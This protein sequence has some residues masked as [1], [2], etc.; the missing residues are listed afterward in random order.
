M[1]SHNLDY[2]S[3]KVTHFLKYPTVTVKIGPSSLKFISLCRENKAFNYTLIALK[4]AW[5]INLV[6]IKTNET[7]QTYFKPSNKL[8]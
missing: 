5:Y 6:P 1:V 3:R 2:C 8:F 4:F 7:K